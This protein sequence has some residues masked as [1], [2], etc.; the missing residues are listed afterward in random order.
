[1]LHIHICAYDYVGQMYAIYNHFLNGL[2]E[3]CITQNP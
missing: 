2:Y 3:F 1:M